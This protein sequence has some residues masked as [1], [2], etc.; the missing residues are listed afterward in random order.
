MRFA[1]ACLKIVMRDTGGTWE[2]SSAEQARL[3]GARMAQPLKEDKGRPKPSSKHGKPG[4]E[5]T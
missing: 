1:F 2:S 3:L 4:V 5:R